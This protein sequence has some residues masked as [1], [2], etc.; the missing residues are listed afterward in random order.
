[1]ISGELP[2]ASFEKRYVRKDG[3][4]TWVNLTITTQRDCDGRPLHFITM[5]QDINARKEAEA[6]LAVAQDSL[7]KSEE[8][9]RMA[10]QITMDAVALNRMDDGAYID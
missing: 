1:M 9:Y 5:V 4:L 10:F 3:S 8:R 6:L 2:T 7:R